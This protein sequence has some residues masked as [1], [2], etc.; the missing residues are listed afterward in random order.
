MRFILLKTANSR[1]QS[2]TK[3]LTPLG[4][5][6]VDR[7]PSTSRRLHVPSTR[8][9]KW[10]K[11]ITII[12]FH[13]HG[14]TSGGGACFKSVVWGRSSTALYVRDTDRGC[15]VSFGWL[16]EATYGYLTHHPP[17]ATSLPSSPIPG[18]CRLQTGRQWSNVACVIPGPSRR[19]LARIM[20]W[21]SRVTYDGPRFRKTPLRVL[22][23]VSP[24]R[25]LGRGGVVL[26]CATIRDSS[27]RHWRYQPRLQPVGASIC[28]KAAVAV[29]VVLY[30]GLHML[31]TGVQ[32]GS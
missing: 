5:S 9:T 28:C 18:R 16:E 17:P 6:G 2:S 19:D 13:C 12:N 1:S 31:P 7:C 30:P 29:A 21:R 11:S 26:Q 8:S 23:R 3:T 22:I 10:P 4:V 27:R 32:F 24:I 14:V 20:G 15:N 25:W